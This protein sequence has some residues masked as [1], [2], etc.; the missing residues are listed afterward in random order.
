MQVSMET[1]AHL[2]GLGLTEYE[3]RCYIAL[4]SL[5]SAGAA[6]VSLVS[7]VPR[8]RVYQVLRGLAAKG[9]VEATRGRPIIFT[10]AP[11]HEVSERARREFLERADRAE[12]EL[13]TVYE[14]QTARVPAPIW[15]LHGVDRIVR[16]EIEVI[17]RARKTL[18]LL[19]GFLMP[20]EFELLR[21]HL[22][23]A[24]LRGV[25]IRII[26]RPVYQLGGRAVRASV[27]MRGAGWEMTTRRMPNIKAVI[28]DQAE[29]VMGF[30]SATAVDPPSIMGIWHQYSEFAEAMTSVYD[31]FWAM[32]KP[33]GGPRGRRHAGPAHTRAGDPA[34]GQ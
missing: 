32:G 24:S 2:V 26:A 33:Q 7:Q 1:H 11:P 19:G 9:F 22:E 3:A 17:G 31:A 25:R 29:M 6:E 21:P 30:S 14:T 18:Y 12:A 4:T 10:V 28:R 27:L 20:G 5:I 16:K 15:L 34:H 13:E 23:R 8:S